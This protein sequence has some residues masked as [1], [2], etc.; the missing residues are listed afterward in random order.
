MA[1]LEGGLFGLIFLWSPSSPQTPSFSGSTHKISRC[2]PT[3]S[4]EPYLLLNER[5]GRRLGL[6]GQVILPP[7]RLIMC[8]VKIHPTLL[9]HQ[10]L[11]V[12]CTPILTG[13]S[14][15]WGWI[16][17]SSCPAIILCIYLC[18]VICQRLGEVGLL[19][20][21][22]AHESLFHNTFVSLYDAA[23]LCVLLAAMDTHEEPLGAC[24]WYIHSWGEI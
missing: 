11:G 4:W 24:I 19:V 7:P 14:T 23:R 8:A 13:S 22:L 2:L 17:V 9:S 18:S 20:P 15:L 16:L 10:Q 1:T 21:L 6:Q 12:F 5:E 3:Q